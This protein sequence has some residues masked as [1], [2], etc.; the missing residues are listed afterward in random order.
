MSMSKIK[1]E[2]DELGNINICYNVGI[3]TDIS[4]DNLLLLSN[5]LNKFD[6][7]YFRLHT[8]YYKKS[9]LI[10]KSNSKNLTTLITH[11]SDDLYK[12]VSNLFN[13]I[14]F[15]IIFTNF[16]E[17]L[18]PSSLVLKKCEELNFNYIIVTEYIKSNL[19]YYIEDNIY[20]NFK[21]IENKKIKKFLKFIFI[22]SLKFTKMK[23]TYENFNDDFKSVFDDNYKNKN[24]PEL[25]LNKEDIVKIQHNYEKISNSRHKIKVLYDKKEAKLEKMNRKMLKQQTYIEFTS[26][27]TKFINSFKNQ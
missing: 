8:V 13:I 1:L 23:I 14:D 3:I 6:S 16:T 12:S 19:I 11:A 27:R 5:V 26:N 22:N 17:Y 20:K 21:N 7:D 15:W 10:Q 25:I 24:Y 4:W 2:D 18:T 9:G